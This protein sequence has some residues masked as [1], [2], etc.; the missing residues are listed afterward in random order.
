MA[1]NEK[2]IADENNLIGYLKVDSLTKDTP[3][4]T[5]KCHP[6]LVGMMPMLLLEY[7]IADYCDNDMFRFNQL[8]DDVTGLIASGLL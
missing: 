2:K 7:L 3:C 1:E 8:L 5:I 4:Y 6:R